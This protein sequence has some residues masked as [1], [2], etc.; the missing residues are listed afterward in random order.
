MSRLKYYSRALLASYGALGATVAYTLISVPLALAYLPT[1]EF[2]LWALIVQIGNF[3]QMAEI[4]MAGACARIVIEHKDDRRSLDEMIKVTSV[5]FLAQGACLCAVGLAV[6]PLLTGVLQVPEELRETFLSMVRIYVLIFAAGYVL[7]LFQVLLFAFQR[8]DLSGYGLMGSF[9]L[10][11]LVLWAGFRVGMGLWS[12]LAS[13]A[14]AVALQSG[15]CLLACARLRLIAWGFW[16]APFRRDLFVQTLLFAKDRALVIVGLQTLGVLPVFLITRFL[17]LEAVAAWTVGTRLFV[18]L[19]DVLYRLHDTAYPALAEM[20]TRGER[21][22]FAQRH[23]S[24][25]ILALTLGGGAG[26]LIGGINTAFVSVWTSHQIV[27]SPTLDLLLAAWLL[28]ALSVH[29]HWIAISITRNIGATRLVFFA[30]ALLVGTLVG[31]MLNAF[32]DLTW[33]AAA[34]VAASAL[35]SLPYTSWRT[36]RLLDRRFS[37]VAFAWLRPGLT[38]LIPALLAAGLARAGMGPLPPAAELA[39]VGAVVLLVALPILWL[40]PGVR[41]PLREGLLRR[42]QPGG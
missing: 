28:L 2:G 6:A 3:L 20:F 34:L 10:Q 15:F 4:G 30:E 38:V 5:L 8:N 13:Y 17:G 9:A 42:R 24:L 26:A 7:R 41:E 16:R 11:L 27:W 33:V 39:A 36:A 25:T 14:A 22:R 29:S 37:E 18:L 31:F 1:R 40:Q 19:R 35:L 21:D 32:A 23:Q 12:L